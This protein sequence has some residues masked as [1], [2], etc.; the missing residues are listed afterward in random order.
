MWID[1]RAQSPQFG[2][3]DKLPKLLFFD[4][5]S[6][7]RLDQTQIVE[8]A[9]RRGGDGARYAQL[10]AQITL[11]VCPRPDKY[12]SSTAG[13]FR[14]RAYRQRQFDSMR[15]QFT[16]EFVVIDLRGRQYARIIFGEDRRESPRHLVGRRNEARVFGGERLLRHFANRRDQSRLIVG[17]LQPLI[18]PIEQPRI[19][20]ALEHMPVNQ[21]VDSIAQRRVERVKPEP[22]RSVEDPSQSVVRDADQGQARGQGYEFAVNRGQRE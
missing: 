12:P 13:K 17:R 14:A 6:S 9:P 8:R 19:I 18:E 15:R 10:F 4:G 11:P 16:F 3:G 5:L 21:F 22:D 20:A 2:L 7:S 1:M